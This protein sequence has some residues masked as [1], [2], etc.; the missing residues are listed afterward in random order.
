MSL[1]SDT[2]KSHLNQRLEFVVELSAEDV[3]EFDSLL[4]SVSYDS[5]QGEVRHLLSNELI[6]FGVGK[7]L[8][9][10]RSKELVR[11]PILHFTLV[12]KLAARSI[13]S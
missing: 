13:S 9:I 1:D 2:L 5:R 8:R 6:Q 12:L 11:E 7:F 10:T 3:S 4:V